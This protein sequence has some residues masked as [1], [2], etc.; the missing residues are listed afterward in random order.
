VLAANARALPEL[1]T[2]GVNGYLFK[3]DD[4]EDATRGLNALVDDRAH[5]AEM[6]QASLARVQP[7]SLDNTI[8]RFSDLY[9]SLAEAKAAV[10]V[11]KSGK[12]KDRVADSE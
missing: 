7:H 8:R 4:V 3:A 9:R 2:T 1:V 5:W 6:G 10:S 12:K 11:G